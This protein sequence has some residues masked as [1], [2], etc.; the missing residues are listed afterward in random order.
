VWLDHFIKVVKPTAQ[1]PVVLV[2]D[3][4]TS[5]TKSI[6][7]LELAVNN[8]VTL[9]QLPA[10]CTHK[11]QPLDVGFFFPLGKAY[12]KG[13]QSWQ[14][15]NPGIKY[16]TKQFC[17]VFSQAYEAKTSIAVAK[18][19]F[20]AC[21]IW[22]VNKDV[23][24]D[25][26]FA[27][28]CS[29]PAQPESESASSSSLV[30]FKQCAVLSTD[31]SVVEEV[32]ALE[33]MDIDEHQNAE[34]LP[35]STPIKIRPDEL[36]PVSE[37]VVPEPMDVEVPASDSVSLNAPNVKLCLDEIRSVPVIFR[38]N[39]VNPGQ[40]IELTCPIFISGMKE[41]IEKK[42][43]KEEEQR[44][45]REARQ[46]AKAVREKKKEEDKKAK[47]AK[48]K[49]RKLEQERKR[50]ETMKEKEAKKLD[51]EKKKKAAAKKSDKKVKAMKAKKKT[52]KVSKVK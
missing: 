39:K 12:A 18:R 42:K 23:F 46:I 38:Q 4:H 21:G 2:M 6:N 17:G 33:A 19:A 7:G 14:A 15:K 1:K 48:Q 27:K 9:I 49:Q 52:A 45:A 5:H 22:P 11:M 34:V 44:V 10:H 8:H 3:G 43:A 20:E 47:E 36:I 26:D 30:D 24:G 25:T 31:S 16:T 41:R 29:L 37:V 32:G 28:L 40:Q 13:V 51:R 50:M 35:V